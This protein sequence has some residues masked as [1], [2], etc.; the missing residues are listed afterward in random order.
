MSSDCQLVCIITF[1]VATSAGVNWLCCLSQ[2]PYTSA[3]LRSG[4]PAASSV[5]T[6]AI[7]G[8]SDEYQ[9]AAT[10]V[11]AVRGW[12]VPSRLKVAIEE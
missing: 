3:T 6:L 11:K 4:L 12:R 10:R 8:T 9:R 7:A 5:F 1:A 2:A